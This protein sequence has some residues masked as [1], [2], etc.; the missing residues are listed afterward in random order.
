MHILLLTSWYKSSDDPLLGSFFEEQARALQGEGH[1]VGI[2]FPDFQPPSAMFGYK[3]KLPYFVDDK[4]LA[5][6]SKNIQTIFPFY[7]KG[8][9]RMH[10]R[11]S[12][13]IF[14]DYVKRFGMPNI[15]H[16]HSANHGGIAAHHIA[17]KYNLPHI[18]TEHLTTIVSDSIKHPYDFKITR[19]IFRSADK[20][21]VVSRIFKDILV[22]A[23]RLHP[24]YFEV[25]HNMVSYLFFESF[26]SKLFVP[27]EDFIFLTNSFLKKRKNHKL[28][29]DA[30]KILLQRK[31]HIKLKVG[32]Y[33]PEEDDLRM[34]VEQQQLDKHVEFLGQL[35][36]QQVKEQIDNCHAFV[37]PSIFET[38]GIVL[39]ESLASGRP[40]VSTD[41]KGP[42]DIINDSNGIIT[43]SFDAADLADAMELVMLNYS[44]YDQKKISDDCRINFSEK[45]ITAKLI[46]IYEEVLDNRKKG[47][48]AF[49]EKEKKDLLLTFD[50]E[51]FLGKRSG[52]IEDCMLNTTGIILKAL[53]PY[54]VKAIFFVDTTYLIRL[55]E[56]ALKSEACRNDYKAIATQIQQ[57]ISEGHYVYPHIHPHW[58]DAVYNEQTNQWDAENA[59]HYRFHNISETERAYIFDNSVQVLKEIIEP[60]QPGYVIDSFRAGGWSVQPFSDFK[61][62]FIKHDFKYEFSVLDRAYQFTEAQY[63]D[64]SNRPD[65]L[66]YH[67]DDDVCVE[68][69]KGR[70]TQF[71]NSTIELDDALQTKNRVVSKIM[72]LA[73]IENNKYNGQGQAPA[74]KLN[75][76]PKSEKGFPASG[77]GHFYLSIDLMTATYLPAY[78]NFFKQNYYMHFVSH[79]KMIKLQSIKQFVK[80]LEFA[81]QNFDVETDFKNMVP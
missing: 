39:I 13:K 32:G 63:F 73:K 22:D 77:S 38:F 68:S 36:R 30:L 23:L 59:K 53:R 72:R 37:L 70:F 29:F 66:I 76:N 28:L 45:S 42:R 61:P 65:K 80:F 62:H 7:R 69:F 14:K 18:I 47:N 78:K 9:Y 64:F 6:Y 71:V 31:H 3:T 20:S 8:N 41:S 1:Q 67:F 33:G 5:T 2:I 15:I 50:Y 51:L 21:I 81:F 56:Q 43:T 11:G 75:I 57:M 55:K 19:E 79:P 25:V 54:R 12:E 60:V 10:G 16:S 4:G 52:S 40:V 34:Y 24:D 49:H 74:R 58:L 26:K 27:G 35:S 17:K 46:R 44:S 48:R